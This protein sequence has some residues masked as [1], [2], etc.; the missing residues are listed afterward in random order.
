MRLA[1][2]AALDATYRR[3]V[4]LGRDRFHVRKCDLSPMIS[5]LR[6][7]LMRA[8]HPRPLASVA[9]GRDLTQ[10]VTRLQVHPRARGPAGSIKGFDATA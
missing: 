3:V 10:L 6:S 7:E 8:V 2:G 1:R 9:V 4:K 5:D